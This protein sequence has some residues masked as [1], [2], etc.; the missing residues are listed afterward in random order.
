MRA[1]DCQRLLL[2]TVAMN[3][4]A[5]A[6]LL[7]QRRKLII[8]STSNEVR[9]TVC[10]RWHGN[11]REVETTEFVASSKLTDATFHKALDYFMLGTTQ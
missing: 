11:S 4:E 1:L 2:Q 10:I 3:L 7:L 8:S 9:R 6:S 5:E